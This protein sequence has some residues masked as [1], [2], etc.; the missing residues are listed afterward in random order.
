MTV[1]ELIE[2]LRV[3]PPEARVVIDREGYPI[4][5]D[6]RDPGVPALNERGEVEL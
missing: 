5:D 6:E 3:M 2:R 4:S 1:I